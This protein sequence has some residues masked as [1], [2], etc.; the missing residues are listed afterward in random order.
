MSIVAPT[1]DGAAGQQYRQGYQFSAS[2]EGLLKNVY[3][4]ALNNVTFHATPLLEMFGDFGGKID[5]AGNKIIKAFKHQGAGGFGAIPEGGAWVTPKMQKGFQGFERIKYL[6][7]YCSLTGPAA[8]TVKEG[9]GAYVDAIS[10]AMDDTLKFARQQMERIIGGDGT[11][12]LAE[13]T[14]AADAVDITSSGVSVTFDVG[15]GGYSPC[16]FLAEGML[17]DIYET[18]GTAMTNGAGAVVTN[19]DYKAGTA[20][21]TSTGTVTLTNA[22]KVYLVLK[23]AYDTQAEVDGG[24]NDATTSCGEPNG[25]GGLV[26]A[27]ATD[28]IWGL[29][30]DTYPWAL[31]S[32]VEAAAGAE[33]DEELLML[34]ILDMVNIKQSVPNVLVTSPKARLKYFSNRKEDRRFDTPIIDTPF[35]FRSTGVVI[36]QYTLM[37]QSLT[38]L[39]PDT[40]YMLNTGAFKFAKATDGFEWVTNDAGGYF[41]QK[42]GSDNMYASAVNYMNFVCEDPKGQFKATGLAY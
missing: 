34:W 38:S 30:R 15:T 8:R 24:I 17:V 9:A 22:T 41:R 32:S 26:S 42:E 16:Q 40:L 6:N 14:T 25:L 1:M 35:G 39:A 29:N 5:F 33:L 20:T 13:W 3:L 12:V 7:A 36:D 23:G 21:I 10:S 11:G 2:V 31:R 27:T 4:P 18:L 28:L 19:V 37:L